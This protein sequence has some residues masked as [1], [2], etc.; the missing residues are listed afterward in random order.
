[1]T[2]K[3]TD[4][5]TG[6]QA[7]VSASIDLPPSV[8]KP[9]LLKTYLLTMH[10]AVVR[11]TL[12]PPAYVVRREGNVSTGVVCLS[13]HGG[14][15]G[16]WTPVPK[17]FTWSL[18]PGPFLRYPIQACSC[19]SPSLV[20]S[21]WGNPVRPVASG[22]KVRPVAGGYPREHVVPPPSARVGVPP[23]QLQDRRASSCYAVGGTLL[24]I[25]KED[26]LVQNS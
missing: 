24:A 25:K 17:F 23:P 4:D 12:L 1:M 13:V 22:T 20:C 2:V 16:G 19:G 11:T 7:H 3:G 8:N 10:G 6:T 15:G 5:L 18:V 14:G 9:T 21:Q 26:C